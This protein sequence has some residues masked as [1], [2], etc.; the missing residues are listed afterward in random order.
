MA[1]IPSCLDISAG[2]SCPHSSAFCTVATSL[3]LE[4]GRSSE[5]CNLK[6]LRVN[7]MQRQGS[8]HL[9]GHTYSSDSP[10]LGFPHG[11]FFRQVLYFLTFVMEAGSQQRKTEKPLRT[12]LIPG[13]NIKDFFGADRFPGA[14]HTSFPAGSHFSDRW[15]GYD[16]LSQ[17]DP[18][19]ARVSERPSRREPFTQPRSGMLTAH[20]AQEWC[21]LISSQWVPV[22]SV[23]TC[24]P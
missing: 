10:L 18:L 13:K 17:L 19:G 4:P 23:P 21:P 1:A 8:S 15:K 6:L 7:E 3:P 2:P 24:Q 20:Q 16:S 9:P 5:L 14:Q 11:T 22:T 12:P